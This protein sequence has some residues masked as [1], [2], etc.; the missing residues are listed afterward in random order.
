[1]SSAE[2][3]FPIK[4]KSSEREGSFTFGPTLSPSKQYSPLSIVM[5]KL[6]RLHRCTFQPKVLCFGLIFFGEY[7]TEQP[8]LF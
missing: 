3:L 8:I 6:F 7:Q 1:M 2:G 5:M 4:A